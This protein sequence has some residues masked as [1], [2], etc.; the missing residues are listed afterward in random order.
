MTGSELLLLFEDLLESVLS[1]VVGGDVLSNGSL[2]TITSFDDDSTGCLIS[3][4]AV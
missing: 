2:F 1:G 4:L 3:L